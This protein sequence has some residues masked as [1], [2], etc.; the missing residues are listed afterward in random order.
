M[1]SNPRTPTP[2]VGESGPSQASTKLMAQWAYCL[3]CVGPLAL[4]FM[5]WNYPP[6]DKTLPEMPIPL[7]WWVLALCS[8]L[9]IVLALVAYHN[10]P[11]SPGRHSGLSYIRAAMT[12]GILGA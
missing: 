10:I 9:G 12:V 7:V 11:Q 5:G 6:I 3:A 2:E 4:T 1:T 8:P